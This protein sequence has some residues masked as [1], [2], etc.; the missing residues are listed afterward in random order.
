LEGRVTRKIVLFTAAQLRLLNPD[1]AFWIT[2]ELKTWMDAAES[3]ARKR[4]LLDTWKAGS[5]YGNRQFRSE[6]EIS[7]MMDVV[8]RESRKKR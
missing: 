7:K 6:A 8:A 1:R 3:L 2:G 5:K 4:G